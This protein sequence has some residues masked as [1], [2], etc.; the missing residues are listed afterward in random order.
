M[1]TQYQYSQTSP[2]VADLSGPTTLIQ[3]L[4]STMRQLSGKIDQMSKKIDERDDSATVKL[5]S[6]Y[7]AKDS[8]TED[9]KRITKYIEDT[10]NHTTEM[11]SNLSELVQALEQMAR[12]RDGTSDTEMFAGTEPAS[13]D[14]SDKTSTRGRPAQPEGLCGGEQVYTG[15]DKTAAVDEIEQL[16]QS[17]Q[18]NFSGAL[19]SRCNSMGKEGRKVQEEGDHLH[20]RYYPE[21]EVD[22]PIEWF[23]VFLAYMSLKQERV[24]ASQV[25]VK[26]K[27][28]KIGKKSSTSKFKKAIVNF[29]EPLKDKEEFK[30]FRGKAINYDKLWE[31]TKKKDETV[32]DLSSAGMEE[33]GPSRAGPSRAGPS[34]AGPSHKRR[35]TIQVCSLTLEIS[36]LI[37]IIQ[38]EG[39]YQALVRKKSTQGKAWLYLA[40]ECGCSEKDL[41]EYTGKKVD[42]LS[43][44][45]GTV[46]K[47]YLA[48]ELE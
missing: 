7:E 48:P 22:Y 36:D 47:Q 29:L 10:K 9:V 3:S 41:A 14:D 5:R 20:R 12:A 25:W 8:L 45:G 34:R 17:L 19:Q 28:K 4:L 31:A 2:S 46:Y 39:G 16:M 13:V 30:M 40:K 6:V 18:A 24:N 35:E 33:A 38:R 26:I 32:I 15:P 21:K 1:N 43:S 27:G 11:W 44:R 23:S 37:R 42:T